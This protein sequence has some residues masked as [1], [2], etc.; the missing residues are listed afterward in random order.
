MG[1]VAGHNVVLASNYRLPR[2]PGGLLLRNEPVH[3]K[4]RMTTV[5]S[6]RCQYLFS[7]SGG[8]EQKHWGALGQ[9]SGAE[10]RM[11]LDFVCESQVTSELLA[12]GTID[13]A[14]H[15]HVE[16]VSGTRQHL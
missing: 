11:E 8:L 4:T 7:A 3:G 12:D 13:T 1:R 10:E 9:E 6:S 16:V 5:A 14:I 15:S 2:E